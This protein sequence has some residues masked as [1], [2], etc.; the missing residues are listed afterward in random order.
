MKSHGTYHTH[1]QLPGLLCLQGPIPIRPVKNPRQKPPWASGSGI[2]GDSGR[3][4]RSHVIDVAE[5]QERSENFWACGSKH[6]PKSHKKFGELGAL[7]VPMSL[8]VPG[9]TSY[10]LRTPLPT[11]RA[12]GP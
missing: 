5:P 12:R 9:N 7:P 4:A 10:T 1:R 8:P 2:G 3:G 11:P 6:G